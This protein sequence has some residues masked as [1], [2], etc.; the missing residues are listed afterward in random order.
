[1]GALRPRAL[2]GC[3][4]E[5]LAGSKAA[6]LGG[7]SERFGTQC[8]VT[9][10]FAV[11]GQ[12]RPDWPGEQWRLETLRPRLRLNAPPPTT[13]LKE[14]AIRRQWS[15][16]LERCLLVVFC[17]ELVAEVSSCRG[18]PRLYATIHRRKRL[19]TAVR[20]HAA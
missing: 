1:M 15:V 13:I 9:G 8:L 17:T 10:T 2:S 16:K 18:A 11:C 7:A 3:G 19:L 14:R 20:R 4:G 6:E 12:K 5:A